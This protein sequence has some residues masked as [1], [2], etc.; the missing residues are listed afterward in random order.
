MSAKPDEAREQASRSS[1]RGGTRKRV[2]SRLNRY[3]IAPTGP[4]TNE[5][6]VIERLQSLGG[7]EVVRTLATTLA[8][9]PPVVVAHDARKGDQLH[10]S[11]GINSP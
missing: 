11:A 5:D 2:G 3:M 10:H 7:V 8:D 4:G 1:S 9:C 6:A